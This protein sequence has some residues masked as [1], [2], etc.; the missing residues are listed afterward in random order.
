MNKK[1]ILIIGFCLVSLFLIAE[2]DMRYGVKFGF[3]RSNILVTNS[4]HVY[5][6][7]SGSIFGSFFEI[8]LTPKLYYPTG[9]SLL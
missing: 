3:N 7:D 2:A 6:T 1:L 4:S 5:Q 9:T 8:K